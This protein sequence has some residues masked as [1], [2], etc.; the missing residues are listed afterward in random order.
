LQLKLECRNILPHTL[1]FIILYY[2]INRRCMQVETT[3]LNNLQARRFTFQK[4]VFYYLELPLCA[5]A[6]L[7]SWDQR[8][9]YVREPGTS[10]T[11]TDVNSNFNLENANPKTCSSLSPIQSRLEWS[12]KTME[13]G[14]TNRKKCDIIL[15]LLFYIYY[16]WCKNN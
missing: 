5:S 9:C 7:S 10:Q 3:S 12:N 15:E 8:K 16:P 11:W 1:Q 4:N 14:E 6:R 2:P 13:C